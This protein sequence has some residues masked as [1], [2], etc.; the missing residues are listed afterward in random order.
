VDHKKKIVRQNTTRR[1]VQER[2]NE[3]MAK[4][5][6]AAFLNSRG[7]TSKEIAGK[8]RLIQ[9]KIRNGKNAKRVTKKP[10][11][12]EPTFTR[13][14]FE[15]PVHKLATMPDWFVSNAAA[16][17]VSI[18][19]PC[20]KSQ[21]YLPD[22]IA[23]WDLTDDGLT[24][25]IIYVDDHCP[26]QSYKVILEAWESRKND[27]KAPVGKIVLNS[28]NSGFAS[29]CNIGASYARG[30]VLIFLNAD[31]TVTPNWIKPIYDAF[32]EQ[33]VGIV[34]S[35]ILRK[36]GTIDS[37]GSEWDWKVSSF[38]H[39]GRQ[40]YNKKRLDRPFTLAN[41]PAE[42]LQPHD[43]EMVTGACL[44]IRTN[45]FNT[46]G[47]FDIEYR[48]AYWE[49]TELNMRVHTQGYR[50]HFVP[51][52]IIYHKVGHT[53]SAAHAYM[54]DNQKRFYKRWV[55]TKLFEGYLNGKRPDLKSIPIEKNSIV[56]YTAITDD[57]D[58]L[59]EQ[60]ETAKTE[61]IEFVAF[62]NSEKESKT[63]MYSPI[64]N[65][66]KDSNRNAKIH[67]V[68]PHLFFPEKEYSLWIDGSVH[69]D[70]PFSVEKLIEI[71]LA[72]CDLAVFNHPDRNCIY[73]EANACLAR[74]LDDPEVIRRQVQRY[75]QNG[76]PANNGLCECSVLLRRHTPEIQK[77]NE[78]W[79]N[80]IKNGSRRDQIS[81][82]YCVEKL[83]L[84]IRLFPGDLRKT[85]FLFKRDNHKRGRR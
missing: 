26:N 14:P 53:N 61:N 59:K 34:G 17:D 40:I 77:F 36:D 74:K 58:D 43:V 54:K 50:I 68:M 32:T 70:F 7:Q 51:D 41:A 33:N 79:W 55:E 69:I 4:K 52:S 82:N 6:T 75:T 11:T 13:T 3:A 16:V 47:G 10:P 20:F 12:T 24:K 29:T 19:I 23:S 80:E 18:I 38:L 56:V 42:L 71:Y 85:N 30:K 60:P 8:E 28:K 27:L 57:Y 72:D 45:L 5:P 15:P 81:F 62:M 9:R 46:I 2:L 83:G 65:E 44:A 37:C 64:C 76:Y 21:E 49:D 84:K 66:F 22:L 25:E 78:M 1:S 63:W 48:I 31:T 39:V 35:L 73:Q 67:K